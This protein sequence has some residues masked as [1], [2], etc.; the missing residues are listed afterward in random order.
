MPRIPT[1]MPSRVKM[2][3]E[4]L[5]IDINVPR[6]KK[7][8]MNLFTLATNVGL[9]RHFIYDMVKRESKQSVQHQHLTLLA[10]ALECDPRFL[11]AEIDTPWPEGPQAPVAAS[12]VPVSLPPAASVMPSTTLSFGGTCERSWRALN[13]PP[14]VQPISVAPDPRFPD[15]PQLVYRLEDVGL[16]PGGDAFALAIGADHF[17]QHVGPIRAGAYVVVRRIRTEL[18]EF[19]LT[20]RIVD[21]SGDQTQLADVR[22]LQPAMTLEA[23]PIGETLSIEAVVTLGTQLLA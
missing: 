8:E 2:R 3:L 15:F 19:Q 14:R 17:T 20:L 22:G 11:T 5:G 1:D 18:Q 4:A 9:K 13:D 10:K 23:P 16:V 21:R 6:T 12:R 7:G